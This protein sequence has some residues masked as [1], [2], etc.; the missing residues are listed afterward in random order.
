[1]AHY[2]CGK[3]GDTSEGQDWEE[4]LIAPLPGSKNGELVIRCPQ[5]ITEY[6]IR[7]AGGHIEQGRGIVGYY[8]YN[9][10]RKEYGWLFFNKEEK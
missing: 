1:M 8:G 3:C 6:A 4:W 9:L 7:K 10:S 5:H 2:V